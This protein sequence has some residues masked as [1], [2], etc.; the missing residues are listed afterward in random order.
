MNE[1]TL[2]QELR[3]YRWLLELLIERDLKNKYRKSVLGY[4]WSILN[5][6]LMMIILTIVFSTIFRFQI[7]NYPVYL[8]SGQLIF[9]FFSEATSVGMGGILNN[10]AMIKKVYIPK[11]IFP[12]SSVLSSFTTM[13]FSLAALVIVMVATQTAFHLTLIMVPLVLLYVLIFS[14]G[15]G[16]LLS[17]LLVQFRDLTYLWGVLLTALNYLIPIFYPVEILPDWMRSLMVFNP[18]Y[19]YIQMFREVILYGQW[20]TIE[21]HCICIGCSVLAVVIG[22]LVFKHKQRDFILYI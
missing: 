17:A 14:I 1:L 19:D 10:G 12:L 22:S 2:W 8:L 3:K 11:Y 20:P 9:T 13:V 5:P 7:P 21:E 18:L 4:L 15:I 16:I 6:L